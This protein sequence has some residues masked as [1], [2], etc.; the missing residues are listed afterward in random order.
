MSRVFLSQTELSPTHEFSPGP[1]T[2]TKREPKPL[3]ID[4]L[5]AG[6]QAPDGRQGRGIAWA[7][8]GA[9]QLR[10]P[11]TAWVP[12]HLQPQP[13]PLL[14]LPQQLLLPSVRP[15]WKVARLGWEAGTRHRI[16]V[17]GQAQRAP[18]PETAVATAPALEERRPHVATAYVQGTGP[19]RGPQVS[20]PRG[21]GAMYTGRGQDGQG[22]PPTPTSH[23]TRRSNC[24]AASNSAFMAAAHSSS[25]DF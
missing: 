6:N 11:T 17:R 21:G 5:V 16:A 22:H 8:A 10:S 2:E 18:S 14:R 25:S 20:S 1:S 3:Y 23:S 15:S 12:V 24:S 13:F 7:R 4:G 9:E 19:G